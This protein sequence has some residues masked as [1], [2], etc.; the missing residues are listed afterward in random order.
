LSHPVVVAVFG[1]WS[2][3]K[4]L[5]GEMK[6]ASKVEEEIKKTLSELSKRRS[7][8]IGDKGQDSQ[9]ISWYGVNSWQ[10]FKDAEMGGS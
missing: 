3:R 10:Y 2:I 9:V 6:D 1:C 5:S 7:S 8:S 4:L